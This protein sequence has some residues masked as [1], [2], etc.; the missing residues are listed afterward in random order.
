MSDDALCGACLIAVGSCLEIVC[1]GACY[2]FATLTHACTQDLCSCRL[3]TTQSVDVDPA[4]REREPLIRTE[5]PAA[6]QPMRKPP[7]D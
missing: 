7:T 6:H 2:D 5:E 3:C 4:E 1:I